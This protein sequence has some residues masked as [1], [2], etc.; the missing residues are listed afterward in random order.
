MGLLESIKKIFEKKE[1]RSLKPEPDTL[2]EGEQM[3]KKKVKKKKVDKK[4]KSSCCTC[5]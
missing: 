2:M 1:E 4:K 5:D 3:E